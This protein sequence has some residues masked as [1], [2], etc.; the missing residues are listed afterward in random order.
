M[1]LVYYD[2][3]SFGSQNVKE[4]AGKGP[5]S[6]P[7]IYMIVLVLQELDHGVESVVL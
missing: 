5:S 3:Y 2:C 1:L 6:S 4:R 7:K